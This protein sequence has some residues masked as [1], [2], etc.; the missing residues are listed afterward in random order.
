MMQLVG[1]A[2]LAAEKAPPGLFLYAASN[3]T[4]YTKKRPLKVASVFGAA[5]GI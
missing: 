1:F 4:Y 3:P 5:D 2:A